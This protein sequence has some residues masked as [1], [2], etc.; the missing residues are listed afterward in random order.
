MTTPTDARSAEEALEA[1]LAGRPVPGGAQY[2]AAFTDAVRSSASA[3]GRPNA[4][5]AEL[6]AT[7]L[8]TD[9]SEPSTRTAGHPARASRK[10]PRMLIPA[11]VAKFASAG[12]VAKAATGT[13]VVA[14]ALTGAGTV[15]TLTVDDGDTPPA[16][17]TAAGETTTPSATATAEPT[18]PSV[19]PPGGTVSVPVPVEGVEEP[20]DLETWQL[21]PTG[22]QTFG[23]WVSA[24]AHSDLVKA[25][26]REDGLTFG[27]VVR[28]RARA[29]GLDDQ[30]LAAEGVDLD[31][32]PGDG[33]EP[34]PTVVPE[35]PT[36]TTDVA[37]GTATDRGPRGNAG[38]HGNGGGNGNGNGGGNGRN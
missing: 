1:C 10:R 14:V 19:A 22:G 26:L 32:L 5:L 25:A 8:L 11:L 13:A 35:A 20:L 30:D 23:D 38:S 24:G 29:K 7:G 34:E 37:A 27:S 6:L 36:A 31:A 21:G 16:V 2:L 4:A 28:E 33:S 9:Q 12:L 18:D 15:V 17:T 3:P